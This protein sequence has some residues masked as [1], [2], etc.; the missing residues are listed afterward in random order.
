MNIKPS[1][2][3]IIPLAIILVSILISYAMISSTPRITKNNVSITS[4]SVSVID[5]LVSNIAHTIKTQGIVEP[6]KVVNLVAQTNGQITSVSKQFNAGGFFK[7]GEV[8]LTVDPTDYQLDVNKLQA[9]LVDTQQQFIIEK[10]NADLAK[11]EWKELGTGEAGPLALREPQMAQARA[12]ILQAE[13]DLKKAQLQLRRTKSTAPFQGRLSTK[14]VDVGQVIKAGEAIGS[15]QSTDY[16]RVRLPLDTHQVQALGLTLGKLSKEQ[17]INVTLYDPARDRAVSWQGEIT[18]TEADV[19]PESRVYYAIAMIKQPY[20][21]TLWKHQAPL[22]SGMF[23]E[24]ELQGKQQSNVLAVPRSALT[25]DNQLM[26]VDDQ[27]NLHLLDVEI[28]HSDQSNIYL[29]AESLP[30]QTSFRVCI[31]PLKNIIE[32]MPLHVID[33]ESNV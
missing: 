29:D 1:I 7:K 12:K 20:D 19:D 21:M 11:L 28:S 16:A 22:V 10:E 14:L 6:A 33:D 9:Q 18:H 24:A 15:F 17:F 31:T 27:N 23:V 4:P 26:T 32:N 3:I 13:S 2:K 8:I 25:Y 5:V 30:Q